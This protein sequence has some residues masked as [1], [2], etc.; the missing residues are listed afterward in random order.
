MMKKV[1]LLRIQYPESVH[2]KI[3][4]NYKRDV[5]RIRDLYQ[6]VLN[7]IFYD[8]LLALSF[9]S[10]IIAKHTSAFILTLGTG[11]WSWGIADDVWWIS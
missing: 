11:N 1:K 2:S 9:L 7:Y 4:V 6:E 5:W 3:G 10:N 8:I